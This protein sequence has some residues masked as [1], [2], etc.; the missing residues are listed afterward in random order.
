MV[1]SAA[2]KHFF[3]LEIAKLLAAGF[4][5][6][7]AAAA[8]SATGLAPAEQAMLEK[9]TAGLDAG[10]TITESLTAD[11]AQFSELERNI[12]SAG[13]R[14]GQMAPAFQHLA[15]YFGMMAAA[16]RKMLRGMMYPVFVLHLGVMVATAAVPLIQGESPSTIVRPLIFTLLGIYITILLLIIGSKALLKAAAKNARLDGFIHALPIVGKARR[17]LAMARFTTVYH[18]SLLAGLNM[19]ETVRTSTAAAHS[20]LIRAAGCK[21]AE[22]AAAGQPLGPAFIK[23]GGFPNAFARSYATAEESGTLDVDLARWAHVFHQDAEQATEAFGVAL[24]K[25]AY[26]LVVIFVGWKI[27]SFFTSYMDVLNQIGNDME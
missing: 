4:D 10:R 26:A 5:I 17:S 11:S 27:I 6:R 24:S 13:E 8:M 9:M 16:R 19:H 14:S 7:K 22:T 20:G 1:L 25:L 23:S 21:V 15:D 3:Y 12:I 18:I 2:K